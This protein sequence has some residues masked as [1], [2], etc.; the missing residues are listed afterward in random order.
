MALV[1][2][3][4]GHPFCHREEK[5]DTH[6]AIEKGKKGHPFCHRVFW[7]SCFISR[8]IAQ[9]V[10]T[11]GKKEEKKDTH[12]VIEIFG[13]PVLF[14]AGSPSESI[15]ACRYPLTTARRHGPPCRPKVELWNHGAIAQ[16]TGNS[17]GLLSCTWFRIS[18]KASMFW[19]QIAR[20]SAQWTGL[21]RWL[22]KS[23][24]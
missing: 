3:K 8:R 11:R 2:E 16:K 13:Y 15:R 21:S 1:S 18:C 17:V 4:K 10:H 7:I 14:R 12:F 22:L 20:W 6:F 9:R 24:E 5:K 23:L 19:L